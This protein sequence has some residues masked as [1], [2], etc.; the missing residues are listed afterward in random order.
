[1]NKTQ[2]LTCAVI[3]GGTGKTSTCA[4]IAQAAALDN[5][6]VLAI[7]LDPQ[8]NL[9]YCLGADANMPGAFELLQGAFI[10][11]CIQQTKQNID[12]IAGAPAL[13]YDD[14]DNKK[15]GTIFYLSEKIETIQNAYDL[16]IIDTPPYFC[17]LTYKA[18]QAATGLIIPM[19]TDAGSI[20]GQNHIIE[21]AK[22]IK[23]TNKKLKILG[24]VVTRYNGRPN[25]NRLLLEQIQEQGKK[26]KCPLL[27]EI[28]QGVAIQE[29]Q[30]LRRN[31]FEY[32]PR[33]KPAQDYKELYKKIIGG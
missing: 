4:A 22:E 31:L 18:L 21:V 2:I 19:E 6:K 20:H 28:R 3:K 32:A 12:V 1:M 11:D 33:S 15:T 13:A 17:E 23:R 25:I 24:C 10:L 5:K 26:L 27:A 29:A 30:A 7:D 8:G 14:A 9:S 16:I